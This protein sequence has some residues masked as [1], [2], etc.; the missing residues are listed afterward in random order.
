MIYIDFC[1][2]PKKGLWVGCAEYNNGK[3]FATGRT[4]DNMVKNIKTGGARIFNVSARQ[5]ILSS[6]QMETGE[7]EQKYY[8]FMNN[9]FKG[10]FWNNHGMTTMIKE[11]QEIE[12]KKEEQMSCIPSSIEKNKK[13]TKYLYEIKD[14][15][16]YVY[17]KKLIAKYEVEDEK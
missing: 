17:E 9:I 14:G 12:P 4:L 2:G 6:K 1:K 7:F 16:L 11:A 13:D 15:V 10:K 5:F 8:K 3:Y